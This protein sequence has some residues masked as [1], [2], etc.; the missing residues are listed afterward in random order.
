MKERISDK[1]KDIEKYLDEILEYVPESYEEYCRNLLRKAACERVFQKIAEAVVDAA[2]LAVRHKKFDAPK[3]EGEVFKVLSDNNVIKCELA[4]K[5]K[6][7]K[8]MRNFIVHEYGEIDDEKVYN[9]ITEE[10]EKDVGDFVK[11]LE[12]MG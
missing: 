6:E 2:F 5:L 1:I 7:M 8:S 10:L 9:A 3:E 11:C 12:R 4:E